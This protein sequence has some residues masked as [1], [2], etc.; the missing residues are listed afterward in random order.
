[1]ARFKVVGFK[2]FM[3]TVDGKAID[4]ARLFVEVKLDNSR[5]SKDQRA[6]GFCTEEIK[7]SSDLLKKLEH[8]PLPFHVELETE[9]VSNGK[10]S[11][12]LVIDARPVAV[13]AD[14]KKVARVA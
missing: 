11:R 8:L 6:D 12:E 2:R 14:A 5:N 13:D 3:G 4:S 9:R 7:L 1:M 10:L